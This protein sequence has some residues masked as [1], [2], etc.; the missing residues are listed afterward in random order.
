MT[1]LEF[2]MDMDV[3]KDDPQNKRDPSS[4]TSGTRR[5]RNHLVSDHAHPE[6][7]QERLDIVTKQRRGTSGRHTKSSTTTTAESSTTASSSSS[8]TWPAPARGNSNTSNE[9]MY[10][11]GSHGSGSGSGGGEQPNRPMGNLSGDVPI[12]LTPIT[13]RVSRAK[14]GVPVHTC[15]ICRPPKV[16]P[17]ECLM[18]LNMLLTTTDFYPGR[19]P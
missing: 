19:T 17:L 1:S 11:H 18:R 7:H 6:D 3:D 4:S 8:T 5:D 13:G 9:D 16:S 2:I 15:D 14:K 12:K 10:R